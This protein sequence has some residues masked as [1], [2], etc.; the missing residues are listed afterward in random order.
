[1]KIRRTERIG[2]VLII[3][4]SMLLTAAITVFA[5]EQ[6]SINISPNLTGIEVTRGGRE[7]VDLSG[8]F[9]DSMGHD[10]TY[11]LDESEESLKARIKNGVLLIDPLELGEFEIKITAKCEA[12]GAEKQITIPV[13]IVESED[14]G[15]PAQYGYDETPA[16]SVTVT[17]TISSDGVPLVG[18]D[19]DNT[20]LAH[21]QVTVP[22]FDLALYDLEQ[23]YR[24]HTENGKGVYID[25]E[26]VERPTAMHM[27]IY[28]TERYYMGIPEEQC[29]NGT[30][31][32]MEYNTPTT[33]RNVFGDVAY[34]GNLKAYLLTGGA[35]SSYMQNFWGHRENLMYYRNHFFPL[36]SP[37]WGSTSDYQL[38]SDGNTFDL[39][40]YSNGDFY[41]GGAFCCFDKETYETETGTPIGFITQYASSSQFGSGELKP[42]TGLDV[43]IFDDEWNQVGV[44]DSDSS[45]YS[46]TFNEPGTYYV[47]GLDRN[48][49]TMNASKAPANAV[50]EVADSFKDIPLVSVKDQ[51][52]KVLPDIDMMDDID[53][54]DHYHVK[55]PEETSSVT[56]EW[57][58][59]SSFDFKVCYWDYASEDVVYTDDHITKEGNTVT[60]DPWQWKKGDKAILIMDSEHHCYGAFT[61]ETKKEQGYNFAPMLRYGVKASDKADIREKIDHTI[62]LSEIFFDPEGDEIAYSLVKDDNE[63]VTVDEEYSFY[64]GNPGKHTLI[65]TAT[66]SKGAVSETY[67]LDL[68]VKKNLLPELIDPD[69]KELN[70]NIR[71]WETA[72]LDLGTVFTDRNDDDITYYISRDN[73]EYERFEPIFED[74]W[75]SDLNGIT[76]HDYHWYFRYK[77]SDGEGIGTEHVYKFKT[78]D[79]LGT[80]EEEFTFNVSV[81]ENQGPVPKQEEVT[82]YCMQN[83]YFFFDPQEFFNDPEGDKILSYKVS[84]NNGTMET[85][86]RIM[87]KGQWNCHAV[88]IDQ[89]EKYTIR[90]YAEDQYGATGSCVV[91]VYPTPEILHEIEN[92]NNMFSASENGPVQYDVDGNEKLTVNRYAVS[93]D[94]TLRKTVRY[95]E[96]EGD[97]NYYLDIDGH[98]ISEGDQ[99]WL[100][101]DGDVPIE[102]ITNSWGGESNKSIKLDA[103]DNDVMAK[104]TYWKPDETHTHASGQR[105]E[106]FCYRLITHI[107]D[108]GDIDPEELELEWKDDKL[109]SNLYVGDLVNGFFVKCRY[110]DGVERY[111]RDYDLSA[112]SFT[113]AGKQTLTVTALELSTSVELEIKDVPQNMV[114]INDLGKYGRVRLAEVL[115]DKN[116]PVNDAVITISDPV[117]DP[118]YDEEKYDG[119][120]GGGIPDMLRKTYDVEV[121][122]PMSYDKDSV[123]VRFE[124]HKDKDFASEYIKGD[125]ITN[126]E[127]LRMTNGYLRID[128]S[129]G[130]G[131]HLAWWF[132]RSGNRRNGWHSYDEFNV[133]V[134][135][136]AC[137]IIG[138]ISSWDDINNAEYIVY[139]S[140]MSD[141]DIRSDAAGERE[142]A[143]STSVTVEKAVKEGSRYEQSFKVEGLDAGTYKLAVVKPGKYVIPV[144]ET[145]IDGTAEIDTLI[146]RLY[147]DI[148]NDGLLDVRD[149][150]QIAR[151]G[152]G[153]RQFTEEENLAAD[154]NLDKTVDVRDITQLCRKIVG[155]SSSLDK[156]S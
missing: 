130:K 86:E 34:K 44:S 72:E 83:H 36:M 48:M 141:A 39:A 8:V 133:S 12:S 146:L 52:G 26:V 135:T 155:K 148:N 25:D 78:A 144:V 129:E 116:E 80:S 1:M 56:V 6:C 69:V 2:L 79:D 19:A 17:C 21:L 45:G 41:M 132:D 15:N 96:Y 84:V 37:G 40:M 28:L 31:G 7:Q 134:K 76:Y 93:K 62:K 128:L 142:H 67:T 53:S 111:V 120:I 137:E 122:L 124:M 32:I 156:I 94:V 104:I 153:K 113:V 126:D 107:V 22:Y 75:T 119:S 59:L 149:V 100:T 16:E 24:Y 92:E 88:L 85:C 125:D 23:F 143:L 57:E 9:S 14:E 101:L 97:Y 20:V 81:V 58:E 64:T 105:R 112:E 47:L 46:Y 131:S 35:T 127:Q 30:S 139:P 114:I 87:H 10:L 54:I 60:L 150:T 152:V 95:S 73:D 154:V 27:L 74:H 65:F 50:V 110:S 13:N 102:R 49:G 51:D 118:E 33:M 117:T 140:N 29:C 99:Y 90:F 115:D 82:A 98:G 43:R 66:D 18:N 70:Q 42:I 55:L 136:G 151:F 38:L 123:T 89:D 71:S 109:K 61:F 11:T 77:P 63:P 68:T 4:I 5:D 91:N 108:S 103:S 138:E 3:M 147:G 106:D 121:R 145:A